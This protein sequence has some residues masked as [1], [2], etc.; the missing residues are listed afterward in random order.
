MERQL[1]AGIA[2]LM[3][4]YFGACA[5]VQFD[6]LPAAKE[7]NVQVVTCTGATCIYDVTDEKTVGE[8]LVDIL[9]VNDN[10]GSMSFEQNKMATAF[11]GFLSSINNLDYR[12]AMTTTDVSDL[13]QRIGN[14]SNLGYNPP[15]P[16]NKYGA[17]QDGKLIEFTPGLTYLERS[18]TN[19][20]NL[21][22]TTVR[23]PETLQCESSGFTQC[24]SGD[25]RGI[26]AATLSIKNY[27]A[28]F[29]RPTAHLAVIVLSDED[30]R[31]VSKY[32]T[33]SGY[34]SQADANNCNAIKA[35]YPFE[36]ADE[37]QAMV[38]TFRSLYPNKT[39]SVHS[40]IVKPGD[41]GCR[42]AQTGQVAAP[43]PVLGE[44]G[45]AYQKLSS[46][47]GGILGNICESNYTSQLQ[48]IGYTIGTQVTSL[49]FRCR[50]NDDNYDVLFNG[51]KQTSGFT[52]DFNTMV[53][54]INTTLSPLTKVTL[55][56]QCT[57]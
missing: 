34:A 16:Y 1:K 15:G 8:G 25:E 19:K 57:K 55:H 29:A 26:V 38:D 35:A 42:N 18:N 27:I 20:E 33:C 12:I 41:I 9:I 40:I 39:M 2:I 49:P 3:L 47:T 14:L 6:T 28:S 7:G 32:N 36:A 22:N 17:L 13:R 50:P 31:G 10:S 48:N 23:R 24:P 21:F 4:S 43:M 54:S 45:Y 46:M 11:S 53:L 52:A 51:V 5:P 56:Y 44:E 30:E 37:P